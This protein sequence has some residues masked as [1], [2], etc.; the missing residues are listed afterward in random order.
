MIAGS[1]VIVDSEILELFFDA[2]L[3]NRGATVRTRPDKGRGESF[4]GSRNPS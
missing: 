2:G 1:G 3:L 4:T